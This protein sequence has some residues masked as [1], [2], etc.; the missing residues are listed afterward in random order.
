MADIQEINLDGNTV[1]TTNAR[2]LY[3]KLGIQKDFSNWIKAQIG[4]AGLEENVDYITIC[5]S[6]SEQEMASN[7]DTP[8]N[9]STFGGDQRTIEYHITLD[10]CEHIALMS[11]TDKG[12]EIRKEYIA[13]RKQFLTE[14]R[15]AYEHKATKQIEED[16]KENLKHHKNYELGESLLRA[17]RMQ[18]YDSVRAIDKVLDSMDLNAAARAQGIPVEAVRNQ[19]ASH[20]EASA[21]LRRM[22]QGEHAHDDPVKDVVQWARSIVKL[23]DAK[24]EEARALKLAR[25]PK[26]LEGTYAYDMVHKYDNGYVPPKE[27]TKP[28]RRRKSA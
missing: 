27:P 4:R 23:E 8:K 15:L 22:T 17:V 9:A 7:E 6:K 28:K 14:Q 18:D 11:N 5:S 24:K 25:R 26:F 16:Y 21:I 10:A 20:L 1:Q 12:K 2:N 19:M 3:T 13:I